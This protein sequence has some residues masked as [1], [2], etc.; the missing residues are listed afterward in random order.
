M[1]KTVTITFAPDWIQPLDSSQPAIGP[2][3]DGAI[4]NIWNLILLFGPAGT[5]PQDARF[6]IQM[7]L[8]V[9]DPA[10][11]I[12][13]RF[14]DSDVPIVG[15][16]QRAVLWSLPPV[17]QA[18]YT[19]FSSAVIFS[20]SRILPD[21]LYPQSIVLRPYA[22]EADVHAL[23]YHPATNPSLAAVAAQTASPAAEQSSGAQGY[24]KLLHGKKYYINCTFGPGSVIAQL[25]GGPEAWRPLAYVVKTQ[26][27]TLA[28]RGF[29]NFVTNWAQGVELFP[30]DPLERAW[31]SNP[32]ITTSHQVDR[33]QN[34][35]QPGILSGLLLMAPPSAHSKKSN[36]TTL[37][38]LEETRRRRDL[39]AILSPSTHAPMTPQQLRQDIQIALLKGAL[40]R[41][42]DDVDQCFDLASVT[43][44]DDGAPI[45]GVALPS[46]DA[47]RFNCFARLQ[48]PTQAHWEILPPQISNLYCLSITST[49]KFLTPDEWPLGQMMLALE[50][51][52]RL[53]TAGHKEMLDLS[54]NRL[55]PI[56]RV[57]LSLLAVCNALPGWLH[58]ARFM[59]DPELY[60]TMQGWS[61]QGR[62]EAMAKAIASATNHDDNNN[63]SKHQLAIGDSVKTGEDLLRRMYHRMAWV[64]N[65]LQA[66]HKAIA[67]TPKEVPMDSMLRILAADRVWLQAATSFMTV[68][69]QR[70]QRLL[71]SD[72]LRFEAFRKYCRSLPQQQQQNAT[73]TGVH[74]PHSPKVLADL[75][76]AGWTWRP[77]M[78]HRDNME[79]LTCGAIVAGWRAWHSP[80][81]FHRWDKH[82]AGFGAHIRLGLTLPGAHAI[83]QFALNNPVALAMQQSSEHIPSP[84]SMADD[85]SAAPHAGPAA[86]S[87][88]IPMSYDLK[89]ESLVG[90]AAAAASPKTN[91]ARQHAQAR[92]FASALSSLGTYQMQQ[93]PHRSHSAGAIG[94]AAAAATAAAVPD[95]IAIQR[96]DALLAAAQA[97]SLPPAAEGDIVRQMAA[98]AGREPQPQQQAAG[99]NA[100]GF[101]AIHLPPR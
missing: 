25:V 76:A 66:N 26:G 46:L 30:P 6:K 44:R 61:A 91:Q 2:L 95:R 19:R 94:A 23:V 22:D 89:D 65:V 36:L 70:L 13:R 28:M 35:T 87:S 7:R 8:L 12:A 79:C 78:I 3:S 1:A 16:H 96:R 43:L 27:Q 33:L 97:G 84:S 14:D 72:A 93:E 17:G 59:D 73:R 32:S 99:G 37:L 69:E 38:E 57:I 39:L 82:P 90:A 63:L 45:S 47:R 24:F 81:C 55:V 53:Y 98:I 71:Q 58:V 42:W 4:A 50:G 100:N 77:K 92:V 29:T 80:W 64:L 56:C 62:V 49:L 83:T 11:P 86:M 40:D 21:D 51:Q 74:W 20:G 31:M 18:A 41:P 48:L 5:Q 10:A 15:F 60:Q 52:A 67:P 75:K 54:Q 34:R 68:T 85:I 101:T 88:S 9:V